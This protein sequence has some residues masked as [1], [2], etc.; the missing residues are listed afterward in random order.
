MSSIEFP[1][2]TNGGRPVKHP[3]TFRNHEDYVIGTVYSKDVPVDF[4][5][6]AEDLLT[7]QT[8][9]WYTVC[10]GKYIGTGVFVDGKKKSLYLHNFVMERFEF[11][12]KGCKESIDHINR[13]GLDNRKANLRLVSQTEQC[14]NRTMKA[15]YLPD[16]TLLPRHHWY[17]KP[18][19][20]HGERIGVD[21]KLHKIK[22]KSTSSKKVSLQD[23]LQQAMQKYHEFC[24]LYPDILTE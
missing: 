1:K 12:G 21:I 17:I 15:R 24:E 16:G 22:W 10:G 8:L 19:G 3:A 9:N 23:K 5:I 6:D 14:V 13:N 11:P 4:Y 2:H 20:L 18:N 7:V